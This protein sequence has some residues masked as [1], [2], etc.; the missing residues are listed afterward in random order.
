MAYFAVFVLFCV[1]S[2]IVN[3]LQLFFITKTI[4]ISPFSKDLFL[5]VLISLPM[6]YYA[7]TNDNDFNLYQLFWIPI[8]IYLPYFMLFIIE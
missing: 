6:F 7:I 5:L 8:L 3:I 1:F 4:K 2:F